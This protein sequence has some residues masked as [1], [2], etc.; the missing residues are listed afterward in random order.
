MSK[1]SNKQFNLAIDNRVDDVESRIS[2]LEKSNKE[3][4]RLVY[5]QTTALTHLIK[6]LADING[7][8]DQEKIEKDFID[9]L[10]RSLVLGKQSDY[11]H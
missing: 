1:N 10:E 8:N 6:E 7:V 9:V 3:L 5:A 2:M 4:S 11:T